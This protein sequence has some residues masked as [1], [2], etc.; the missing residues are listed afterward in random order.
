MGIVSE[1][2][3]IYGARNILKSLIVKQLVGK[4]RS[5]SLGF[6]WHFIVP[7]LLLSVYFIVF[8]QMRTSQIDDFLVYLA[9]GVFLF[10]FMVSNLLNSTDCIVNNSGIVKKIYFPREIIILAQVISSFIVMAI[11][12]AVVLVFMVVFAYPLTYFALLL[13]LLLFI[14]MIFVTGYSLIFSSITVYVR[15]VQ[16]I[17]SS[18]SMVFFFMTPIYFI[19]DDV[20]GVLGLFVN[21]NP[22]TYFVEASHQ[23]LYYGGIA[24]GSIFLICVFLALLS[25]TL[26]ILVFSKLKKGFVERL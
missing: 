24:D 23:I 21:I 20:S 19:K 9:S 4:Y 8:T 11:G 17:L 18:I 5:S 3:E 7:L 2:I 25:I 15:D 10:N 14:S 22:F 12:Y 16:H 13:P 6:A 1:F 26:G